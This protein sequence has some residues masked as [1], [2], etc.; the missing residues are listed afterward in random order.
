M[1]FYG[2]C[3]MLLIAYMLQLSTI[4]YCLFLFSPAIIMLFMFMHEDILQ[5][6]MI[7]L[8]NITVASP[9]QTDWVTC[10]MRASLAALNNGTELVVIVENSD[11]L[12]EHLHAEY[13]INATVTQDMLTLLI[14][15]Q[16]WNT[17]H[18]LWIKNSGT[19]HG[20]A[21]TWKTGWGPTTHQSSLEWIEDARTYTSKTDA[22]LVCSNSTTHSYTLTHS[23]TTH[24][25][26]TAEQT[27]QLLRRYSKMYTPLA[28][29]GL[30]YEVK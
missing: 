25:R 28:K 3:A 19:I 2:Y 12:M 5:R 16:L 20:I 29:E 9:P 18:M 22:I 10:L 23:D 24:E 21:A 17:R 8:K 7:A 14:T 27:S 6:N 11:S 26:L 30:S 4:V 13:V 1:H 15:N